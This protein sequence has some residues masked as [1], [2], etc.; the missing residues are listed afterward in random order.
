ME[1]LDDLTNVQYW[2][3]KKKKTLKYAYISL[4]V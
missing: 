1:T 2:Q 3:Q 4:F